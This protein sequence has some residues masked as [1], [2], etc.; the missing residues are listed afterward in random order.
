[1]FGR[2]SLVLALILSGVIGVALGLRPGPT[3]LIFFS[4][5]QGDCTLFETEGTAILIDAGP[6]TDAFD[7]GGRIVVPRLRSYGVAKISLILLS[8]PDSDH[9]GGL[10]AILRA[11]P[12]AQVGVSDQF[13]DHPDLLT[14]LREAGVQPDRVI[15][16]GR[17]ADAKIGR[18]SLEIR[19]PRWVE[20]EPDNDGSMF[21]RIS[22]GKA[23]A[24]FSGDASIPV[25]A[26]IAGETGWTAQVLHAGHHGSRTASG[27]AWLDQIQPKVAVVSCGR[28]NPYGHPHQSVLDAL[29]ERGIEVLRTD[30]HRDLVF[31]A[32][33]N[34][35]RLR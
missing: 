24:V 30:E 7:A 23:S 6:K 19:T 27:S 28:D 33:D 22:D 14:T 26:R 2:L 10:A 18:F 31:E 34:G 8:H 5:G 32:T 4:V 17:R 15:W 21:V 11:H 1:V 29:R 35:F 3:R 13:R 9:I 12:G 25:E 20:G 16:F